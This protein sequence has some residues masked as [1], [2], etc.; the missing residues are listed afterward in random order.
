[1]DRKNSTLSICKI[2]NKKKKKNVERIHTQA[3]DI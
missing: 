1:M 3:K 2:A